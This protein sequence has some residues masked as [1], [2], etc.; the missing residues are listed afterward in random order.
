MRFRNWSRGETLAEHLLRNAIALQLS[1]AQR[2]QLTHAYQLGRGTRWEKAE[3]RT[4]ALA[5]QEELSAD[6]VAVIRAAEERGEVVGYF[7]DVGARQITDRDG[8]AGL[9]KA[10]SLDEAQGRAA[11]A[12]RTAYELP[13]AGLRSALARAGEGRGGPVGDKFALERAFLFAKLA[14]IERQVLTDQ[15]N[16]LELSI[17]RLVA[18]EAVAI[19]AL[20]SGG[21]PRARHVETLR[22]ALS[23]VVVALN[24]PLPKRRPCES[25]AVK[26]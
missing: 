21:A 2:R 26:A 10:K 14:Q 4:I 20:A 6:L 5:V 23:S 8:I 24:T 9:V 15:R 25:G 3:G 1:V 16:G 22:R 7:N 11:L 13:T 12:Y 19:K 17:L 18:G